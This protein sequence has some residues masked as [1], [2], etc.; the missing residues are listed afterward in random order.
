MIAVRAWRMRGRLKGGT[1]GDLADHHVCRRRRAAGPL[2]QAAQRSAEPRRVAAQSARSCPAARSSRVG[3][4][5]GHAPARRATRTLAGRF[6]TQGTPTVER[7]RRRS[8][9]APAATPSGAAVRCRARSRCAV[10]GAPI[11]QPQHARSHAPRR[12]Q[13]AAA[14][15]RAARRSPERLPRR[16]APPTAQAGVRDKA[17]DYLTEGLRRDP[18]D[19]ALHDALARAW[20]DWGFPDRGLTAAHRAVYYAPRVGGGA[21][22]ARHR[23]VGAGPAGR[24]RDRR[25][26]QAAA[27]DPQAWL[28]AGTTSVRRRWPKAGPGK[29]TSLCQRA[30]ARWRASAAA[31]G[32]DESRA[33]SPSPR[34]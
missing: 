18:T 13:T 27:L 16:R 30:D 14:R 20:R 19:A 34:R 12:L 22:H 23:A 28:R 3:R 25:S 24:R 2:L 26:K 8:G 4:A 1:R 10:G 21:Q 7:R 31:R 5:A 33:S 17:F 15:A 6:V 32:H 11:E 29:P 9:A